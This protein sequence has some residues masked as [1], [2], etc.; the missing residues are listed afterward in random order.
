[1]TLKMQMPDK[2]ILLPAEAFSTK[3]G[4]GSKKG[5]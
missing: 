1:M 5:L 2:N 3:T 4:S